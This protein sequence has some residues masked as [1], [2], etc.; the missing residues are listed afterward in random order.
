MKNHFL[1]LVVITVS[2]F[3]FGQE[4]SQDT[5]K[6]EFKNIIGIDATNLVSRFFN[7]GT[8]TPGFYSPYMI[9]YKRIFKN[10]ALRIGIGGN[11]QTNK[12]NQN[13]T[14]HPTTKRNNMNFGIGLEH[15]CFLA[16]RWNFYFGADAIASYY[17]YDGVYPYS[18]SNYREQSSTNYKYGISPLVGLQFKIN[19]RISISTETSY[20][21]VY[22]Y[23]K[24]FDVQPTTIYNTH[25]KSSGIET[26]FN[27]PT[28]IN[29]RILF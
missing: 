5:T 27:A 18:S 11:F 17:Y 15:Y 10:N 9:C 21:I 16:K 6:K 29:F 19:S 1:T 22:A 8:S 13:D 7:F 3:A 25:S 23:Y 28:A 4:T 20:D 26:S 12:G 24:S 2:T 14:L